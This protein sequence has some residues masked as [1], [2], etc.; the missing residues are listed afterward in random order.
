MQVDLYNGCKVVVV[1][2][3]S[4]RP[5]SEVKCSVWKVRNIDILST[6]NNTNIEGKCA[7]NYNK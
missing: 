5:Q 7:E 4:L 1:V 2:V 3:F 6:Q